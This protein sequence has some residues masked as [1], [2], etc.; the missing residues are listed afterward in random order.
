MKK[1]I[2]RSWRSK[3][4]CTMNNAAARAY[5][6][7]GRLVAA[8]RTTRL[9]RALVR[10]FILLI[11]TAASALVGPAREAPDLA[12]YVAVVLNRNGSSASF[13]TATVIARNIV[14][15][16][17]H[18]VTAPD[19]TRVFFRDAEGQSTMLDVTSI[20]LNPGY[21]PDAVRRRL[22]SIDLALVRLAEP[23]PSA[24]SP[25][26]L[27]KFGPAAAA[28]GQMFRIAG[29]GVADEGAGKTGGVLR[30]GDLIA[31]GPKS[32]ILLWLADPNREGLGA[33]TGDSGAPIFAAAAPLLVAVA[34]WAKGENGHSCGALTQA[35]LIAP[36]RRWID[37]TLSAWGVTGSVT[38]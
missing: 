6:Q 16:A 2:D 32:S 21:R 12:P 29:F 26:A 34:V 9:P 18:C 8:S 5:F 36:Q 37:A 7:F 27:P 33:C 30:E 1:F 38:P 20:A 22:V 17:A 13:C 31:S 3:N 14:L 4:E 28:V 10:L 24:F 35:V 11:P 19:D 15:T 23:L 25:V